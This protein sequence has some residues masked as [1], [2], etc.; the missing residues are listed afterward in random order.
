[1]NGIDD[2]GG[3]AA[4]LVL[5]VAEYSQQVFNAGERAVGR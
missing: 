1:V 2:L 4:D 5:V 3:I